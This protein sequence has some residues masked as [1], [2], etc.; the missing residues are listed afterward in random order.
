MR[1]LQWAQ[2]G[3]KNA[4]SPRVGAA[5]C[6]H[7]SEPTHPAPCLLL[8]PKAAKAT[9]CWSCWRDAKAPKA[10]LRWLRRCRQ[11]KAAKARCGLRR[12]KGRAAKGRCRWLPPK[13]TKRSGRSCGLLGRS[14]KGEA[15]KASSRLRWLR[16]GCAKATKV[17]CRHS[18]P[19][20]RTEETTPTGSVCRP[21]T[22]LGQG[23]WCS[24]IGRIPPT[25]Q[26][27]ERA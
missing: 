7:A 27:K 3:A 10:P 1:E 24:R 23:P 4:G 8:P 25:P 26:Y 17:E 2:G 20:A 18:P 13:A 14:A 12:A 22:G 21:R 19:G 15:A 16:C 5:A 11:A 6:R 9:S